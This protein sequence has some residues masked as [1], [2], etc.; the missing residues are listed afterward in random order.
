MHTN[1][2]LCNLSNANKLETVRNPVVKLCRIM[3]RKLRERV[4]LTKMGRKETSVLSAVI[5]I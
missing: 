2:F 5:K 4:R 3:D 1:A